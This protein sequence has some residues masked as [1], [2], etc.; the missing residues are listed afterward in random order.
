MDLNYNKSTWLFS[1]NKFSW[2]DVIIVSGEYNLTRMGGLP[3]KYDKKRNV[4]DYV[5]FYYIQNK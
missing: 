4:E 1:Q 2:E 3:D 5:F